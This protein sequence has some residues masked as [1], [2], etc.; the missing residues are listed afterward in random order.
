MGVVWPHHQGLAHTWGMICFMLLAAVWECSF[1]P[2]SKWHFSINPVTPGIQG[3][4]EKVIQEEN[5]A[6]IGW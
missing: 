1:G 6:Q 5:E 4:Q 2:L 3:V